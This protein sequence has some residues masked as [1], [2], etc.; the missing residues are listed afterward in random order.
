MEKAKKPYK[1]QNKVKYAKNSKVN[2][3]WEEPEY[4]PISST[5]YE[6]YSQKNE[7]ELKVSYELY[8]NLYSG[9][10][11]FDCLKLGVEG[12]LLKRR[13]YLQNSERIFSWLLGSDSTPQMGNTTI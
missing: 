8:W 4:T 3:S 1:A 13:S 6:N 9:L 7:V 12:S 11:G 10:E 5:I 2:D